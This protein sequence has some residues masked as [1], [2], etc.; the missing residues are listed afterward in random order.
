MAIAAGGYVTCIISTSGALSCYGC[1]LT[2]FGAQACY[3][4]SPKLTVPSDATY[5]SVAVG[6]NNGCAITS[7]GILECWGWDFPTDRY[8]LA[9]GVVAINAAADTDTDLIP[10]SVAVGDAHI[11]VLLSG[12]SIV[13]IGDTSQAQCPVIV[14]ALTPGLTW[15]GVSAGRAHSCVSRSDGARCVGAHACAAGA[16]MGT[17]LRGEGAASALA[18]GRPLSVICCHYRR[19]THPRSIFVSRC[20]HS[21]RPAVCRHH[22]SGGHAVTVRFGRTSPHPPTSRTPHPTLAAVRAGGATPRDSFATLR[23]PSTSKTSP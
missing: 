17:V 12:S 8:G 9:S 1:V 13:C 20:D 22:T 15:T 6:R 7:C 4:T 19:V 11:V 21:Y 23:R 10:A 18:P 5:A 3:G 2:V 16:A 14:P